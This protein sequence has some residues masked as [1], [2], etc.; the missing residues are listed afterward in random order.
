MA[1][2]PELMSGRALEHDLKF[3]SDGPMSGLVHGVQTISCS[4]SPFSLSLAETTAADS[5]QLQSDVVAI[6]PNGAGRVVKLPAALTNGPDLKGRM[7]RIFNSA[8][9][10]AVGGSG[11]GTGGELL[12]LQQSDGTHICTIGFDDYVDIMFFG[13][14]SPIEVKKLKK[15]TITLIKEDV[16]ALNSAPSVI[17]PAITTVAYQIVSA[18]FVYAGTA[19]AKGGA[20]TINVIHNSQN[21]IGIAN[22][23]YESAGTVIESAV[24][25]LVPGA[26]QSITVKDEA[27]GASAGD[28]DSLLTVTLFYYEI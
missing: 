24:Q 28:T 2:I 21:A 4:G 5:A 6:D 7:L 18:K 17:L 12:Q 25:S 10:S 23:V 3:A 20:N 9:A 15:H 26:N 27:G 8:D 14:S 1:K 22:T 16:L 19:C 11:A 13:Q